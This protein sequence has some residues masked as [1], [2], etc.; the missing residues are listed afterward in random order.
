MAE[1]KIEFYN[2]AIDAVQSGQLPEALK[3]IEASLTED[4]SDVH[5]W[6]LYAVILN[7][8]GETEK[9]GNLRKNVVF[10]G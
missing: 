1:P 9:A 8:L 2:A 4:P 5:S 10:W 3:A 6:Q 7:A